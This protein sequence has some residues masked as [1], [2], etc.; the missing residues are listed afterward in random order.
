MRLM[1]WAGKEGLACL[2]LVLTGVGYALPAKAQDLTEVLTRTYETNPALA[3]ARSGLFATAE[4]LPQARAGYLPVISVL[5]TEGRNRIKQRTKDTNNLGS[6]TQG[7][8]TTTT[9][10]S[11]E[12]DLTLNLYQGGQTMAATSAAEANVASS[13]AQL[14]STEQQILLNATTAYAAIGLYQS[15]T[16][17]A[18]ES[19]HELELLK[20]WANEMYAHQ[21]I[22]I[23]YVADVDAQL[24]AAEANSA[25][26]RGQLRSAKSQCMAITGMQLDDIEQWPRLPSP[27]ASKD[28]AISM[29]MKNNPS[30]QQAE[31]ALQA[32]TEE[33]QRLEGTLLPSVD[34]YSQTKRSWN[35]SRFTGAQDYKEHATEDTW[36]FGVNVTMPIFQGGLHYAQ[37]RGAKQAFVQSQHQLVDARRTIL[38]QVEEQWE[39]L[40]AAKAQERSSAEMVK[41]ANLSFDGY[42]HQLKNGTSTMQDVLNAHAQLIS[43]KTA[44]EQ[45]GHDAFVATANL[46]AAIGV[47]N[48]RQ[49]DLPVP[50]FDTQGYISRV[51]YRWVGTGIE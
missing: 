18:D 37:V 6:I 5:G 23:T 32:N 21:L 25:A 14:N 19:R 16:Q 51:R 33:V 28:E 38:A 46:L 10:R 49:L 1:K 27:P 20:A 26:V 9:D 11:L 40:E 48:A 45:A 13:L 36:T 17:M 29:A 24:A 31:F 47:F 3:A 12:L 43:A 44:Q 41:A 42:K 7:L 34:A 35:K 8:N 39:A 2:L 15:L 4:Q 22:T 50:Q 30:I